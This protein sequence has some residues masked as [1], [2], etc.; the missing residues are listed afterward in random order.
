MLT[1]FPSLLKIGELSHQ[2]GVTVKTIRY[3]ENL[4]L[5]T[6]I[7]RSDGNFRLFSSDMVQR[8]RFIKRL[9]SLGLSLVEIQDCL[10]INDSGELPCEEIATKLR[11]HIEE[12]NRRIDEL[13]QLRQELSNTLSN[14]SDSP[15]A[16][17]GTICPNLGS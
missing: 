16:M 4:G 17:L 6:A 7:E 14:W 8:L 10:Q 13:M 2:S 15:R 9:Q 11:Q 3:Y 12:I 5:L 1:S